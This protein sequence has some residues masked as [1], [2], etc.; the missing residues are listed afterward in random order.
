MGGITMQR[1]LITLAS[2]LLILTPALAD[3]AKDSKDTKDTKPATKAEGK[4]AAAVAKTR[5]KLEETIIEPADCNFKDEP[6]EDV[7]KK[8]V[9]EAAEVSFYFDNGVA[10]HKVMN[11]TLKEKKSVKDVLDEMFKKYDLGYLI[12][13]KDKEADRYEGWVQ[14]RLSNERGDEISK[15]AKDPKKDAKTTK[16]STSDKG[17]AEKPLKPAETLNSDE[18]KAA[19]KLKNAKKFL[20]MD[21]K[22]DARDYCEEIIKKYPKTKAAEEAKALLEKLK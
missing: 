10:R 15:D 6:L 16:P 9:K 21:L 11:Y 13:R 8:I 7:L 3:N 5:K 20:D 1:L 2:A 4:D 18:D 17:T 19:A 22:G 14:I 12:H